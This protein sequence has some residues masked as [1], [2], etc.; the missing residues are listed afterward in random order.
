MSRYGKIYAKA[1]KSC[2]EKG[3]DYAKNEVQRLERM[4]AKVLYFTIFIK[5]VRAFY[6]AIL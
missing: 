1:A 6:I 4:L 5:L 2:M 3:A